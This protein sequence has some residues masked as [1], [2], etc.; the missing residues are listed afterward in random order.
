MSPPLLTLRALNRATLARQGLLTPLPHASAA[1]LVERAG[2][3]QAQHPDWPPLALMARLPAT[4]APVDLYR[5]RARR[6]VVRGSLMRMTVHVVSAADFWPM[7]TLTHPFRLDQWRLLFKR[8]PATSPLG[9]RI[10]KAHAVGPGG[11]GRATAGDPRDRGH[12]PVGDGADRDPAQP[13]A[14]AAFQRHG[15]AHPRPLSRGDLRPGPVPARRG[16]ARAAAR[17]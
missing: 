6:T 16:V 5:A 7:S 12:P 4:A 8:D 10:G 17:G 15:P 3:L 9:K 1:R 2:S 14:V 13:T 11:H